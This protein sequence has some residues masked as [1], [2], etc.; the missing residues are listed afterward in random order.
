[1]CDSYLEVMTCSP[2]L[3]APPSTSSKPAPAK[4][5]MTAAPLEDDLFASKPSGGDRED[6]DRKVARTKCNIGG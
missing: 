2:H 5:T 1:M 3:K 4:K 6:K